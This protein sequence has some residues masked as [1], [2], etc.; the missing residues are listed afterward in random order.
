MR[1]LTY[2]CPNCYQGNLYIDE[3]ETVNFRPYTNDRGPVIVDI[4]GI[5]KCNNCDAEYKLDG[6]DVRPATEKDVFYE[7]EKCSS[8]LEE[9]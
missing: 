9:N 4:T 5:A 8:S 3:I 2:N 1:T 7:S 6:R